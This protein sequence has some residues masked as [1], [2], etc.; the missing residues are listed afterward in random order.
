MLRKYIPNSDLDTLKMQ[1]TFT[2]KC[3]EC[4]SFGGQLK[5]IIRLKK[6]LE[7]QGKTKEQIKEAYS[8]LRKNYLYT[9]RAEDHFNKLYGNAMKNDNP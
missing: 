3:Q 8:T 7:K 5:D 4:D 9:Y 1:D 6:E 2:V